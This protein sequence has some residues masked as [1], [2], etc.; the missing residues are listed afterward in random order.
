M[1]R[2]VTAALAACLM[3]TV[4]GAAQTPLPMGTMLESTVTGDGV[5]SFLVEV[6]EAGFLTVVAR[7]VDG[8]DIRLSITDDEGQLLPDGR[9][10]ADLDGDMGAEQTVIALP[11]PGRYQV[12]VETYGLRGTAFS[13]GGSFLAS[14]LVAVPPDPD[15]KPSGA[16]A[17]AVG[18][19]H[20]D[21]I[22]PAAGDGYDWFVFDVA[23]AGVLTVLTRSSDGDL[24]LDLFVGDDFHEPTQS[25]DQDQ[26]GVL[27]NESVTVDVEVGQVVRVRVGPSYVGVAARTTYRIAS[28]IIPG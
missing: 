21:V 6:A 5:S 22:D 9:V 10:D 7:S 18:A 27:G 3:S 20:S 25:S 24:A 19:D 26:G 16:I 4:P 1:T 8:E 11:R 17:L 23:E 12:R 14:P 28:G 15:G 13:V 2:T